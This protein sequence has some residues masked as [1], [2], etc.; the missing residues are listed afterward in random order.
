[1]NR[2]WPTGDGS[3]K[4]KALNCTDESG[5]GLLWKNPASCIATLIAWRPFRIVGDRRMKSFDVLF[6][7]VISSG[8]SEA[9][10]PQTRTHAIAENSS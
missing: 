9:K 4:T 7:S 2:A 1:M 10:T 8:I 6:V 5:A 3:S